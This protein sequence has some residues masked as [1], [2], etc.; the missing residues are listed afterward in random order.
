MEKGWKSEVTWS[1]PERGEAAAW[2]RT[3]FQWKLFNIF[4]TDGKIAHY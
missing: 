2:L 3:S 1:L 4:I